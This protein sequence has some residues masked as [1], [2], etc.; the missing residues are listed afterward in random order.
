[1]KPLLIYFV[2]AYFISWFIWSPLYLPKLGITSLP[3]LPYQ[4]YLGS[5]GPA[6]AAFVVTYSLNGKQGIT[7]LIR[8]IFGWRVNWLW[9]AVVVMAT[10]GVCLLAILL[11]KFT[12]QEKVTLK[13]FGTSN[14][15]PHLSVAGYFL[16]NLFTFGFGEEIGWRGFVLPLSQNKYKAFFATLFLTIGWACWHLPAFLYRPSYSSMNVVG[17]I[18]FFMSLFTGSVLLTWLYN[19]TKGSIFLV[20][21]FHAFVEIIFMS[22]NITPTI[23]A[24]EGAIITVLAISIIVYFKPKNLSKNQ[25][26]VLKWQYL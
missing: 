15:F 24:Y 10:L 21:L 25:R 9:Y 3:V 22:K 13:G 8:R 20:A 4:H 11:V 14:E 5:F 18:E 1:M 6:I 16:L 12:G 19:S 2:L 7:D 17:A 26:Q 23:S